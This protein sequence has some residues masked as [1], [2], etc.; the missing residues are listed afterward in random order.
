MHES[1]DARTFADWG[2]DFLKYD[3][4]SYGD[5]AAGAD[6]E[7]AMKPY[8][9]MGDILKAERLL[10]M[11]HLS[12]KALGCLVKRVDFLAPERRLQFLAPAAARMAS[13]ARPGGTGTPLTLWGYQQTTS[14]PDATGDG[15]LRRSLATQRPYMRRAAALPQGGL[16]N[17]LT[18]AHA[19]A[20]SLRGLLG[21][22]RFHTDGIPN[23]F[24][25]IRI[26]RCAPCHCYRKAG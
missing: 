25:K 24:L 9:Q 12:V 3:W 20:E 5:E 18:R 16:A 17:A 8:K 1:R 2:F 15:A 21:A 6:R 10:S 13:S 26:P 22:P 23:P 4:C 7:K 14:L 11:A 19:S